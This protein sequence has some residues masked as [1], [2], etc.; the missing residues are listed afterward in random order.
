MQVV[1][2]LVRDVEYHRLSADQTRLVLLYAE[3]DVQ[4]SGDSARQATAFTLLRSVTKRKLNPPEVE[5]VMSTVAE[6]AITSETTHV[7]TNCRQVG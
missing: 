7:R 2:V 3:R 4:A 1:G 5:G 6:L